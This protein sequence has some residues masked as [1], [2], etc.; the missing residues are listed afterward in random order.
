MWN[1][2]RSVKFSTKIACVASVSVLWGCVENNFIRAI[3]HFFRVHISLSRHSRG[4]EN[5]LEICKSIPR[6]R[7]LFAQLSRILPTLLVFRWGEN[8]NTD[9]VL[10][11]LIVAVLFCIENLLNSRQRKSFFDVV[12]EG[13]NRTI[14]GLVCYSSNKAYRWFFWI[15]CAGFKMFWAVWGWI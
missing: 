2:V 3:E 14:K 4:W 9:K 5:S 12:K 13:R 7:L 6:R 15:R 1:F 10:Y 11:C 8:V